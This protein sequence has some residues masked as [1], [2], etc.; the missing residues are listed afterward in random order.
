MLALAWEDL[1][2]EAEIFALGGA[3]VYAQAE[4]AEDLGERVVFH[5]GAEEIGAKEEAEPRPA[6]TPCGATPRPMD[7]RAK[8]AATPDAPGLAIRADMLPRVLRFSLRHWR[9]SAR[10][11]STA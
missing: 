9:P 10:R 3:A 11:D 7:D 8:D 2:G 5:P 4:R 1:K 6:A